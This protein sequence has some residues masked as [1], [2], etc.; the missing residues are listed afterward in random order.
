[1]AV[2][3]SAVMG[4]CV[5]TVG[6][7]ASWSPSVFMASKCKMFKHNMHK[8]ALVLNSTGFQTFVGIKEAYF[9]SLVALPIPAP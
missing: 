2:P 6:K 9:R 1:M 3:P 7:R 5:T 8:V 4:S